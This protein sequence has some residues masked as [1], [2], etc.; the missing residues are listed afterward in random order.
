MPRATV[1]LSRSIDL[2]YFEKHD[3]LRPGIFF[4][5]N[6]TLNRG[7][8]S[9]PSGNVGVQVLEREI[10]LKYQ[11][12][13]SDSGEILDNV[14]EPVRLEWGAS[15][16]YRVYFLCPRCGRRARQIHLPPGE[17]RFGC[18][19]CYNLAYQSQN[20]YRSIWSQLLPRRDKRPRRGPRL[21]PRAVAAWLAYQTT[22]DVARVDPGL[23][24]LYR[25]TER[26][27]QRWGKP[28]RPSKKSIREW[29]KREKLEAEGLLDSFGKPVPKV[30]RS[31]G[32]PR[33]K[34][35]YVWR[36]PR[37]KH[38]LGPREAYCVKC[39]EARRLVYAREGVLS[40]GRPALKGRCQA[41]RTC[42]CKMLP[43]KV[44]SSLN[45]KAR[46]PE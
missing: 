15:G 38:Q 5:W 27:K 6:W 14:N 46:N 17:T 29:Q 35:P 39:K 23:A 13:R 33:E 3:L 9:E 21:G 1:E 36:K 19:I 41:C 2:E 32:R 44:S 40:N 20:E 11:V 31:P 8:Y 22:G 30:K 26:L 43:V 28:G 42:L 16:G 45:P 24:R 37:T 7:M 12:S 4:P 18:R 34:Q 10:R 25:S